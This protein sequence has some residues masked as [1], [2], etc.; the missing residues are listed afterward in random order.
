M[1]KCMCSLGVK[2]VDRIAPQHQVPGV[3][4]AFLLEL[5]NWRNKLY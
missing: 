4:P 5:S 3:I 1:W 2:L